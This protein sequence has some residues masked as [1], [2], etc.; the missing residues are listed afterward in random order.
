MTEQ[1]PSRQNGG[2]GDMLTEFQRWLLRSSARNMRKEIGGQVRRTF[3]G[4]RNDNAD[5]WDAATTEVP[6]EVG[7][8][9]ECQWCPICRAARQ[10]R[11]S[12]PS[13]GGQLSGAGNVVAAAVQDAIGALDSMLTR[14]AGSGQQGSSQQG[15]RQQGSSQ[16]GARQQGTDQPGASDQATGQPGASEQAT[17]QPGASEQ[18][19][20]QPGSPT[21][22]DHGPDDRG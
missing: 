8:A 13:L 6:P 3:G 5:V 16:Q 10:M 12:G 18:A 1:G 2:G 22:E 4:G 7:E 19:T 9:P 21:T 11:E 17:G 20:G 15:T 14:A